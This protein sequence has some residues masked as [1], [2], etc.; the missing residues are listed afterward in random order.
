MPA[1][2]TATLLLGVAFHIGTGVALQLGPFPFY[3][4]CLY[5]PLVP[6]ERLADRRPSTREAGDSVP[7]S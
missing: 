2:R 7:L 6:W 5:L 4:L 3:M 1:T